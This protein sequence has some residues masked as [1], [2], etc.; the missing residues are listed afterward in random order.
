[1]LQ[2]KPWGAALKEAHKLLG[3]FGLKNKVTLT[4]AKLSIGE[5]Q[6]VA[7]ARAI[8][9]K[10]Q[11]LIFD[12]PTA[13]LD[14]VAGNKIISFIKRTLLNDYHAI[15]IVTHDKRIYEFATRIIHLQDG[16]IAEEKAN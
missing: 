13:S 7:I 11:I 3:L 9:T 4:P 16:K 15:I 2:K 12:E 10:P 5:Q 6:R 14:S 1:V 8:I